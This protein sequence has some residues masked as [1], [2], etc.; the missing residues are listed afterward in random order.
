[1]QIIAHPH[2]RIKKKQWIN[3]K[4]R[5]KIQSVKITWEKNK[6]RSKQS[7]NITSYS[8]SS[9]TFVSDRMIYA[10]IF[11]YVSIRIKL[12]GLLKSSIAILCYFASVIFFI[13][14][15]NSMCTQ[16]C[17]IVYVDTTTT[18]EEDKKKKKNE[19]HTCMRRE[20]ERNTSETK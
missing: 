13:T 1:M 8:R 4:K 14:C 18:T 9:F 10:V 12:D 11:V 15:F 20:N 16:Q 7:K 17:T 3:K 19:K 6:P 2:V 5:K